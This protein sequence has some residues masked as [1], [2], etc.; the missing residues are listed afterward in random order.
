MARTGRKATVKVGTGDAA[1]TDGAAAAA[2]G[3]TALRTAVEAANGHGRPDGLSKTLR[4]ARMCQTAADHLSQAH[5]ALFAGN[6]GAEAALAHLDAALDCLKA[7]AD[8]G[9]CNGARTAP[10]AGRIKSA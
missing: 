8:H 10:R 1:V 9:G 3:A 4:L 2:A 7:V 6:D 5:Q